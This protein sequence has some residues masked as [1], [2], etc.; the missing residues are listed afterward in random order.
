MKKPVSPLTITP[1]ATS[2]EL[3]KRTHLPFTVSSTCPGCGQVVVRDYSDDHYLSYPR[4]GKPT[5]LSFYHEGEDGEC[6]TEWQYS[7][8]VKLTMEV[9]EKP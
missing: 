7:V 9:V 1:R 8:V 4:T 5:K 3:D 6:Q 2:V